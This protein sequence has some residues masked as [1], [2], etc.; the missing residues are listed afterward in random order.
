VIRRATRTLST[1]TLG[2]AASCVLIP[3]LAAAQPSNQTPLPA[4]AP[5]A[6]DQ[7]GVTDNL[8][9]E[10]AAALGRLPLAAVLGTAL[11]LRPRR[12]GT[13]IRQPAVIQTQIIL[14]V[15]GALIMLVVGAS[16]A[17]AFGIVGAANLIRYRAKIDDPK[18]AVVMLSTLT[19]GL[20]AGVELYGLAIVAT[21]FLLLV[22]WV[23]E[24]AEPERRKT[25]DLKVATEEPADLR[26][27]V[28]AILRRHHIAYELRTLGQKDLVYETELP[29]EVRT[30][31][32]ANAILAL[33]DGNDTEV[34]WEEKKKKN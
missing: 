21:V 11:A 13:P 19:L 17:R 1:I 5:A 10:V 34:I 23:V 32:V 31:R 12:R 8:R 33:R 22:L 15:V 28:E 7:P 25:F 29:M 14:S 3:V 6:A 18:D 24:S 20:T 4:Q 26:S 16:L 30:D 9:E 27:G 2:F